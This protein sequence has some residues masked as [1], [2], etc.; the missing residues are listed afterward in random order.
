MCSALCNLGSVVGCGY[1]GDGKADAACL[2]ATIFAP[3]PGAG[4]VGLCGQLCDC[5]SDCKAPDEVCA[6]LGVPELE[7][8]WSRPGY[9]RVLDPT[10]PTFTLADTLDCGSTGSGGAGGAPS[11]GGAPGAGGI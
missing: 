11:T 7:Q 8:F 2:F 3:D 1:S 5:N 10:D 6:P 4:D 9:C